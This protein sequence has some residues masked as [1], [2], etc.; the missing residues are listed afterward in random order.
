MFEFEFKAKTRTKEKGKKS[1]LVSPSRL[2]LLGWR[3]RG[4]AP[5]LGPPS[6]LPRFS[7]LPPS[8]AAGHSVSP[9][10]VLPSPRPRGPPVRAAASPAS[11]SALPC[12]LR[13]WA[14]AQRHRR[15]GTHPAISLF[16]I[17]SPCSPMMHAPRPPH[18]LGFAQ[19]RLQA[20]A[21]AR[22][23]SPSS[24]TWQCGAAAGRPASE[25][26]CPVHPEAEVSTNSSSQ[27]PRRCPCALCAPGAHLNV[28]TRSL[29]A[30]STLCSC[31]SS[32]IAVV[33]HRAEVFA[34]S[35]SCSAFMPQ[36]R[37]CTPRRSPSSRVSPSR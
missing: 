36:R 24:A 21:P 9:A 22:P 5:L 17:F 3:E 10:T 20:A 26:A 35:S 16:P 31:P 15:C 1:T 37:A 12:L 2:A 32:S 30:S 33:V 14:V 25:P 11:P 18:F 7:S 34:S 13:A 19:N 23:A 27:L 6:P 29:P 28:P 8:W 4:P